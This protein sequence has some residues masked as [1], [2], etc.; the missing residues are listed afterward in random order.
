M[1]GS[2]WYNRVEVPVYEVDREQWTDERGSN[3]WEFYNDTDLTV[4]VQGPQ[5]EIELGPKD[6]DK[7]SHINSF[8]FIVTATDKEGKIHRVT[9]NT[10]KHYMRIVYKNG[11]LR[12]ERS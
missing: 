6:S 10:T 2:T 8:K 3:Y 9:V 5:G 11:K 1:Y 4:K 7:V 12:V